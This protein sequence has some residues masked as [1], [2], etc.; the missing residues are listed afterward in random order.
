MEQKNLYERMPRVCDVVRRLREVLIRAGSRRLQPSRNTID[1]IV[2]R[3]VAR[4]ILTRNALNEQSPS[5][6]EGACFR[7]PTT[8]G[9]GTGVVT[10]EQPPAAYENR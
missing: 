9:E 10:V 4:S 3:A 8:K 2:A 5:V 6:A 7:Q 1:G